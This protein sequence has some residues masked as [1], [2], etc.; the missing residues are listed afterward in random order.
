MHSS[1]TREHK[2]LRFR[3]SLTYIIQVVDGAGFEP[4]KPL[5]RGFT[6]RFH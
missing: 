3:Y 4:A 5:G 6:V 2:N 1:A